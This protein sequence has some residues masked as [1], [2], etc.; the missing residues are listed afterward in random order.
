MEILGGYVLNELKRAEYL[1]AI[2]YLD[3]LAI[4]SLGTVLKQMKTIELDW[5]CRMSRQEWM[6]VLDRALAD[7]D[8]CQMQVEKIED[9]ENGHKAALFT[10]DDHAYVIF[11]GTGSDKEWRITQEA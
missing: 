3:S 9:L 1:S 7:E 5:P 2:V 4:G 11:R 10:K 6:T 8:L